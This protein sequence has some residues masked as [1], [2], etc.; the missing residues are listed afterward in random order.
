MAS[1]SDR[2]LKQVTCIGYSGVLRELYLPKIN[3][4]SRSAEVVP[5]L[6]SP[7][8]AR[9]NFERQLWVVGRLTRAPRCNII[10]SGQQPL[11]T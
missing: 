10:V 11:T 3:K 9:Y 6:G 5:P 8:I 4:G 1:P 7:D 2:G